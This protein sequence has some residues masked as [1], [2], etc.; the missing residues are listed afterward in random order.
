MEDPSSGS[1]G[2]TVR[3]T[4]EKCPVLVVSCPARKDELCHSHTGLGTL[5]SE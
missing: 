3:K 2:P 4:V 5:T 1:G